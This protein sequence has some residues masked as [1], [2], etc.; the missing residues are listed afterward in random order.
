MKT[1]TAPDIKPAI[2]KLIGIT[3]LVYAQLVEDL[4]Y[5][6]ARHYTLGNEWSVNYLT[7][8]AAF[9]AWWRSQWQLRD[10]VFIADYND[11]AGTG[12]ENNLFEWWLESHTPQKVESYPSRYIIQQA[13]ALMVEEVDQEK[14][15]KL[16]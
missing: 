5:Q 6:F 3:E 9:W 8:T 4:G 13:W 12:S 11:Y 7:K 14:G 2:L 16:C 15:G 1:A 10:E